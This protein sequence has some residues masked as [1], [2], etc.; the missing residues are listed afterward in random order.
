MT[1][2]VNPWFAAGGTRMCRVAAAGGTVRGG[3]LTTVADLGR[4][5]SHGVEAGRAGGGPAAASPGVPTALTGLWQPAGPTH[6]VTTGRA[7]HGG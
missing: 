1:A 5:R 2:Q 6:V 3:D 4:H 7:T